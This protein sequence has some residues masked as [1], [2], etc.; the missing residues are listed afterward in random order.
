MTDMQVYEMKGIRIVGR[1]EPRPD[2]VVVSLLIPKKVA[3]SFTCLHN[4]PDLSGDMMI[5][6][7]ESEWEFWEIKVELGLP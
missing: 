6:P 7:E 2:L 1:Y 4:R 5:W 3:I